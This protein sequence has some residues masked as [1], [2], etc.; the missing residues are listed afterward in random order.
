MEF[1][2]F[3]LK[4]FQLETES[5]ETNIQVVRFQFKLV[6]PPPSSIIWNGSGASQ[7]RAGVKREISGA[8]GF[9]CNL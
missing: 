8:K 5:T 2:K 1:N 3:L 6:I 4:L 7:D 9:S